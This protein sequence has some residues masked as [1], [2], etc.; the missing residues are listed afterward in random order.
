MGM[1]EVVVD[2]EVIEADPPRRLVQTW[3]P[4]WAEDIAA[5]TT[6]VT[7]DIEGLLEGGGGW[8]MILSDL[9][10]CSRRVRASESTRPAGASRERGLRILCRGPFRGKIRAQAAVLLCMSPEGKGVAMEDLR[11]TANLIEAFENG[12]PVAVLSRGELDEMLAAG[13]PA[14]LWLELGRDDDEDVRLL[15]VDLSTAD[16]E[17]MLNRSTG[18]DV[19]LALD[20]YALHGL[21][22]D[23]EVE[24]HGLRGAL[25]IAVVAGAIAAP[26]GVAANPLVSTA[27]N[28]VA[29]SSRAQAVNPAAAQ[30][31]AASRVQAANPAS[32]AQAAK[33]ASKAQVSQAASR[34]LSAKPAA[35]KAQVSKAQVSSAASKAQLSKTLVIKASGLRLLGPRRPL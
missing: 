7:H 33:P 27:S 12:N 8:P 35:A 2:G 20:G 24:A 18:D 30:V 9:K 14:Q 32:R 13:E 19:L 22:D 26:A 10:S 25:A 4:L 28:Q 34:A 1:P 21:F 5:E 17:Q 16:I 23:P 15:S 31:S 6:R 3:H 29:A 11:T